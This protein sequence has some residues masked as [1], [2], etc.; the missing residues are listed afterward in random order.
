MVDPKDNVPRGTL[1]TA[2][3][4][5]YE[6]E[7]VAISLEEAAARLGMEP[8]RLL[9][10]AIVNKIGNPIGDG[11]WFYPSSLKTLAG[12]KSVTP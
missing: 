3:V 4:P 9:G 11:R 8:K 7:E 12:I 2:Y 5:H 6:G 10:F 1:D